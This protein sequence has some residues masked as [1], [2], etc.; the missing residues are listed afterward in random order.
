MESILKCKTSGT[1]YTHDQGSSIDTIISYTQ[2]GYKPY[3]FDLSAATDRLPIYMEKA[4]LEA[5][6]L[7]KEGA[8]SWEFLIVGIPFY[9]SKLDTYVSYKV[10]QGMGA[11]SS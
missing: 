3:S 11:Y 7:S 2:K 10:G 9:T 5:M 1:D 8:D 6:G 4:I